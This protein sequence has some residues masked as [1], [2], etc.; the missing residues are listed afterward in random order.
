MQSQTSTVS[1]NEQKSKTNKQKTKSNGR[2]VCQ[3]CQIEK[4][5]LGKMHVKTLNNLFWSV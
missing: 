4:I 5:T 3:C 1:L 2:I